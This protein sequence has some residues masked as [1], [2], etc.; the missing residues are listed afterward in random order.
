[1]AKKT[2]STPRPMISATVSKIRSTTSLN[3]SQVATLEET[4]A[5]KKKFLDTLD[6]I[7]DKFQE[8]V[9]TGK[10]QLTSMADFEK[11]VK[12]MLLL[13]GEADS[14]SGKT[15]ETEVNAE[16]MKLSISKIEEI[17]QEDDP[18]VIAMY[19]R[20]YDKYNELNDVDE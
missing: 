6:A 3:G 8:N 7:S 10:V 11:A 1:M 15:S 14:I 13:S 19:N 16:T 4:K 9:Q 12:L 18:E 2:P 5:R 17:L 20:I